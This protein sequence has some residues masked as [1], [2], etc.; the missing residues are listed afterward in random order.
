MAISVLKRLLDAGYMYYDAG[1]F[2]NYFDYSIPDRE[3]CEVPSFSIL[4]NVSRY[5]EDP[6]R[7]S[8]HLRF[9][10]STNE[11]LPPKLWECAKDFWWK[12]SRSESVE[13]DQL[14]RLF[15]FGHQ[16]D[17]QCGY[18]LRFDFNLSKDWDLDRLTA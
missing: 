6:G 12:V 8:T 7:M 2:E 4:A 13:L 1:R 15:T 17:R 9:R 10:G 18:Y 16:L 3:D 5:P 14:Y 11:W